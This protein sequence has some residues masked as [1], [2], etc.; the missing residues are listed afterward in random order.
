V[1]WASLPPARLPSAPTALRPAPA[2]APP[3]DPIPVAATRTGVI[4]GD[5][6]PTHELTLTSW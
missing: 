2:T 3:P 4:S 1:P 6:G 5:V